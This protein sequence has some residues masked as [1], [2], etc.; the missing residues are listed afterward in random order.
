M[1]R[2]EQNRRMSFIARHPTE[3]STIVLTDVTDVGQ[4]KRIDVLPDDV[5][6][7]IFES[8]V[9]ADIWHGGSEGIVAWQSL[10]HVCRRW[11]SLVF[12]S[13]R[14]LNLRLYCTPK[15]P[16]RDKLDVW[17]ALPLVVGGD[18]A[19]ASNTDNVIAA[20]GQSNRVCQIILT[21][22]GWQMEEV[23][24]TMQVPFPEL[25]ELR[26]LSTTRPFFLDL[27]LFSD[28]SASASA[29]RLQKLGLS[30]IPFPRLPKLLSSATHLVS[31]SLIN[32]PHSAYISPDTMATLL[33]V[34]ASLTLLSLKFQSPLS[35]PY[36]ESRSLPPSKRFILPALEDF[37]FKGVTEYLEDL[38]TF[39]DAPQLPR[40]SITFFNQIDFDCTR[41]AQFISRTA[42]FWARD[43]AHI[44]FHD[45]AAS[46]TLR[47]RTSK[48]DDESDDLKIYILCGEP[49]WQLSSVEQVCTSSLHTLSRVE[50]LYVEHEYSELVW[51][52]DAIESTLWSEVLLPFTAVKNLY[53][54]E[55]FAPG[56]AIALQELV[57]GRITEV[58]PSLQNIFV[59]GLEPSGPFRENIGQ[60]IT[61][62]QLSGHRIAISDWD[63]GKLERLRQSRGVGV[64]AACKL[65]P[66]LTSFHI[67]LI[68]L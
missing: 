30:G 7:G 32:I 43:E 51:K 62:R 45:N 42:T 1:K 66:T 36:W 14:R 15:T 6:L 34:S 54:S 16:T 17:P 65:Q 57:G 41:L 38:V 68:S 23:L 28:G 55:E 26:L 20:L 39:I 63:T 22:G 64:D 12:Q 11:R 35:R 5:L 59:Q 27:R 52:N 25:T 58:L 49:D 40:T 13:P 24:A 8:Y 29:P 53:L 31:L 67:Y 46:L 48:I 4:V 47:Y 50:D 2:N 61:T 37:R 21:V 44:Q 33:S 10:V 3:T 18:L 9:D 19:I 60:F 56:I